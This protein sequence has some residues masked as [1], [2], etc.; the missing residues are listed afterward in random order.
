M[1][2]SKPRMMIWI[3]AFHPIRTAIGIFVARIFRPRPVTISVAASAAATRL[4]I[5][6]AANGTVIITTG[7]VRSS[8]NAAYGAI[9]T[10]GV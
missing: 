4:R 8:L 9:A 2:E 1:P 7:V 6:T 5:N 3:T 10:I